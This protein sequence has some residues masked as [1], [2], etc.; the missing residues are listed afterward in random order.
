MADKG[1]NRLPVIDDA[2]RVVGILG[3]HEVLTAMGL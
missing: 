3:R 2:G 1:I